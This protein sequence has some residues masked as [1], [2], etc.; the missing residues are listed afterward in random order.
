[1]GLVTKKYQLLVYIFLLA[2]LAIKAQ[3]VSTFPY[4]ENF[5]GS[6]AW[7]SGGT[8][9]DWAW[10]A[11]THPTISSAGGGTKCWTVGGLT[12]SFYNYSELSWIKSP[13]FDFSSLSYPWIS[14]KIF[15]E[16][17]WKYD[18][19]VL[20]YSLNSGTTWTNV[21]AYGDAVNCLNQNWYD[22]NNITW[23]TSAS[24]KHGWTGRTGATSGSCQG[25]NGSLGWVTAKHCMSSLAGQPNV[26]FRFLF[27]SGTTCNSYDGIAID[28]IFID[29]APPNVANFTYACAG[30]N[31][32]NFTNA[33]AMC[34]T[35]YSW[36][37]GDGATST[38]ANPSHT[39]AGSG[40]YN[41][42][43]TASGPCNASGSV[44]IPVSILGV[45]TS[46]TNVSCNGANDGTA[47][48]VV[49]GGSGTYTY[50][51][52]PGGAT[53]SG[54]TGLSTG[55]YTIN[56]SAAGSCPA[57]ATAT[58]TQP[59][60]LSATTT[61]TPISCFGGSNGSATLTAFGGTAPYSYL[62]SPIGGS[63]TTASGLIAGTYTVTVTD[64]HSCT[65]TATAI[66]TQPLAALSVSVSQ[67]PVSCF[68]GNNGAATSSVTGG[69][70]PYSYSWSPIGGSA[71]TASTLIA[72]TY[73][74]TIT[75]AHGCTNSATA[76]I[77]Q[78]SSAL[79]TTITNTPSLCTTNNGTATAATIGGTSPYSY[80]WST[81]GGTTGSVTGLATGT[82]TVTI[83]DANGCT[84][85]P[86]TTILNSG[87]ITASIT[88]TPIRCFGGTDGTAT[89]STSGGSGPYTYSWTGGQTSSSLTNLGAGNYC[90]SVTDANGCNDNTCTNI[91]NPP[92]MNINF[93]SDPSYTDMSNPEIH[94]TDLSSGGVDW[95]WNFGDTTSSSIENPTHIY[96][97]EGTYP[98]TLIVTNSMGCVDSVTHNIIID[99]GYTF[100]APN[101]FTPDNNGSNDIFLPKG[102]DW[103]PSTF[104]LWIFDRWGNMIFYSTDMNHGWDGR[105]KN[106]SKI[107]EADVYVWK[108]Q[109][110]S[111]T[112]DPHY[113]IGS[114]SII[115]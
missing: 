16:D 7:T 61:V 22:Y 87:S 103:N 63:S 65:S 4:S 26:C 48:T 46:V 24:P 80:S 108:V 43:L 36:D 97:A 67:T 19:M 112:G 109:L 99:N 40:I 47:S 95:Q 30:I 8:N 20:Q 17:E 114:V 12:G 92:E 33:S 10:G 2:S 75:D 83:S 72:G 90:V 59:T 13:C 68:S 110:S 70:S 58:I 82:Y 34:P 6:P 94:F 79:S 18:G 73:T 71:P 31:T 107:A 66:I 11:P 78:P 5:E 52:S 57:N 32:V 25:G 23:L 51:W 85:T 3:C 37:F 56:V 113:Y 44:T 106:S 84:I 105:V 81:P 93:S 45:S 76:N 21:G 55:T 29:N 64:A 74:I 15:W 104:N 91:V 62:W 1:M 88:S 35:G 101:A 39:Y 42:T 69:T 60:I 102:T 50:S 53:T 96:G 89:V 14:F 54:V 49:S 27:G 111:S 100:Y 38:L 115:R 98:V 28:D 9:S 86:T 41:V 77:T